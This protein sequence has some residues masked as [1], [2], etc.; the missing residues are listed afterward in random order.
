MP[1]MKDGLLFLHNVFITPLCH[2]IDDTDAVPRWIRKLS[3]K[4]LLQD[5]VDCLGVEYFFEEIYSHALI[6]L[7]KTIIGI[8]ITK[9]IVVKN[10]PNIIITRIINENIRSDSMSG[11]YREESSRII[12]RYATFERLDETPIRGSHGNEL[13]DILERMDSLIDNRDRLIIQHLHLNGYYPRECEE[14]LGYSARAIQT[15]VRR[16][17]DNHSSVILDDVGLI[18]R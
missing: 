16:L 17:I 9:S 3:D 10:I 12:R 11:L 2:C 4:Y 15:L 13:Q 5:V 8:P 14:G 1:R 7:N 6:E 18:T